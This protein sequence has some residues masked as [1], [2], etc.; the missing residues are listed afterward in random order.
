MNFEAAL[1]A[2]LESVTGL[3]RKVY[4]LTGVEVVTAPAAPYLIF[5]SSEGL[6]EKAFEGYLALK[7]VDFELNILHSTY[8]N[9][10]A[11]TAAVLAKVISFQSRVIGTNGPF[12]QDITY[13][14]PVEL[15]ESEVKM[16]R[17]NIMAKAIF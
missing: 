16:Y 11:L 4:G 7:E 12:I 6:Q 14:K 13:E 1:S 5:V 15:Y 3:S 2:E 8:S 10:K 9:M 17:S